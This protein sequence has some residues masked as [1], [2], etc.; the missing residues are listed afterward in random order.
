MS[1]NDERNVRIQI[2]VPPKSAER[3]DRLV[4]ETESASVAEVVRN[5]IRLYETVIDAEKTGRPIFQR[6]DGQ[7]VP[8]LTMGPYSPP[9]RRSMTMPVG[10]RAEFEAADRKTLQAGLGYIVLDP[11]ALRHF[12]DEGGWIEHALVRDEEVDV[13]DYENGEIRGDVNAFLVCID[14]QGWRTQRDPQAITIEPFFKRAAD[15]LKRLA[16]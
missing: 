15:F 5:A 2:L 7:M 12:D 6:I 4:T 14:G 1:T 16:A 9:V 10:T 11:P 3:L 13:S 8:V